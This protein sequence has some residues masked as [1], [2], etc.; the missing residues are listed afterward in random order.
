MSQCTSCIISDKKEDLRYLYN[1][2]CID[3]CPSKFEPNGEE[4]NQCIL[5][6]LICPEGFHINDEG[7]G[8]IPNTFE[9]KEG[10][11]I[12]DKNTACIPIPGTPI[13]FPFIFM[14]I[15]MSL[16]VAYSKLKE[17]KN[18]KVYT[19]LIMFLGSFEL[20]Q[21]LLM[22]IWSV[23]LEQ[24]TAAG[25]SFLAFFLLLFTNI[26]F[27]FMYRR[28]VLSDSAFKNW[29]RIYKKTKCL[30]PVLTALIN[31]KLIRFVISGFYGMEN[32]EAVFKNPQFTIH[33]PLKFVTYFKYVFVY[34]PVFI[35]DIL[36]M[37]NLEWGHQLSV[38]AIETFIF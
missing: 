15:C 36:I 25:L 37:S 32:T 9:C 11:E 2:T 16:A 31:F 27:T 12:N 22:A 19:S 24:F 6:G 33:R 23:G 38:L 14:G 20:L 29:I 1:K 7:D 3:H 21:Y 5:V 30:L 13:P 17:S 18:T 26:A 8:C 28:S 35:A 34:I 4:P 10:Y